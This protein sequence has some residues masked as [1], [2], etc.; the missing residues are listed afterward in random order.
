MRKISICFYACISWIAIQA[1]APDKF[2][3]QTYVQ[4]CIYNPDGYI[5]E[6][7]EAAQ[8]GIL[9]FYKISVNIAPIYGGGVFCSPMYYFSGTYY[10]MGNYTYDGQ[11]NG[12]YIFSCNTYVAGV[13]HLYV[14]N[15]YRTVR[16]QRGKNKG[17]YTEYRLPRESDSP[18]IINKNAIK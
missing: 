10:P 2:L 6:K 16:I 18:D 3:L 9:D 15:D 17:Y 4:D 11:R 1:Q 13:D 5:I 7:K 14:S 12:W 8:L